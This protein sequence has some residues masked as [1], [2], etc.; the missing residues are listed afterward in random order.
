MVSYFYLDTSA[1][2][3]HYI[4]ETG[5]L[6]VQSL[7][8]SKRTMVFTSSLTAVEGICTFA[9]LRRE[10]M[11]SENDLAQVCALFRYDLAHHYEVV[12]AD[13]TVLNLAQKLALRHPLRAYDTVQLA[14]AKLSNAKLLQANKSP[15]TFVCA[16]ERLLA[17]ARAE[18]LSVN[19]PNHQS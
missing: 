16:D 4:T 10:A 7:I 19:N 3:K 2:L 17:I 1:L 9:R 15:L 11:F 5:S 18:D 8:R 14:T 13:P 6:W 12:V